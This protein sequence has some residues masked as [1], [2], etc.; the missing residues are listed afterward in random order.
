MGF[1]RKKK[2]RKEFD[3]K[4]FNQLVQ[5][6]EEW[7]KQK[8]LI[9]NSFEPSPEVLHELKILEAKYLFY[10]REAKKRNIRI[11]SWH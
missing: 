5:K 9:Q 2:L 7:H 4:L 3:E 10:L 6:K 8:R 1:L 11:G